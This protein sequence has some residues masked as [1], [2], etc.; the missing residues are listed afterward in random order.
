MEISGVAVSVRQYAEIEP[1][2]AGVGDTEAGALAL[3][4]SVPNPFVGGTTLRFSMPSSGP[5]ELGIYDVTGRLVRTLMSRD[6]GAVAPGV[7]A[8]VWDG[9][10]AGG[11]RVAGGLY[12]AK[13]RA[14]QQNVVRKMVVLQ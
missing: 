13:L 2:V 8:V 14:L 3:M 12:F 9:R 1:G 7:H 10:D 5:V 6:G 4:P 11:R